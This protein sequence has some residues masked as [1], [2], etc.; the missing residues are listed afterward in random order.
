MKKLFSFACAAIMSLAMLAAP[1]TGT[2]TENMEGQGNPFTNG[3]NYSF[4][5]VEGEVTISF[6]SLE[7]YVGLVA[8]SR[9]NS[10]VLVLMVQWVQTKTQSRLSATT[11]RNIA[12]HTSLTTLR[13]AAVSLARTFVSAIPR[14]VP[15]IR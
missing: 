15:L 8:C 2:S 10:T 7:N 13:R 9:L 14:Y 4:D 5:A 3:Y 1:V 12:R 11:R 6:T